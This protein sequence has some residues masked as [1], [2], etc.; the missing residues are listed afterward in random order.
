MKKWILLSTIFLH[1]AYRILLTVE[2]SF[3]CLYDSDLC[4]LITYKT[5][6]CP[7]WIARPRVVYVW[8]GRGRVHGWAWEIFSQMNYWPP[9]RLLLAKSTLQFQIR[10]NTE[11]RKR[12]T[13]PLHRIHFANLDL[14]GLDFQRCFKKAS[15][16]IFP[17]LQFIVL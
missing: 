6:K 7:R 12:K 2:R 5:T 4:Y 16:S 11:F 1:P 8:G 3:I 15:L 13:P 17:L 10:Q 9:E 14:L